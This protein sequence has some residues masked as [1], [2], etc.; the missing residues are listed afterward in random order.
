MYR[1]KE[2]LSMTK[3]EIE[4]F[5]Q[6]MKEVCEDWTPEEVEEKYGDC[7]TLKEAIDRRL[8]AMQ[9]FYDFVEEVVVPDLEQ[10]GRSDQA[11]AIRKHLK[12]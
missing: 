10:L 8:N 7:R 2:G 6:I 12:K 3:K 1:K 9:T 4:Q 5:I 11:D